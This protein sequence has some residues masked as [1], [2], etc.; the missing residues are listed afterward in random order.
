MTTILEHKIA[1]HLAHLRPTLLN[2][3]TEHLATNLP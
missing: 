3:V 1:D 2:Q